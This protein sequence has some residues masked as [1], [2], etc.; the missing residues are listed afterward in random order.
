MFNQL[1]QCYDLF[2]AVKVDKPYHLRAGKIAE[3]KCVEVK[4][5]KL[6]S[7]ACFVKYDVK[8]YDASRKQIYNKKGN[9]IGEMKI[10]NLTTF[11]DI[12]DV[13]LTVKF[14]TLSKSIAAKV[15]NSPI[16]S[17]ATVTKGKTVSPQKSK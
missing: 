16:P 10:C 1:Y 6:E 2:F 8:L 14:K 12:S 3:F 13:Q 7:G 15:S 4:W 5:N 17:S 9:N 11:E